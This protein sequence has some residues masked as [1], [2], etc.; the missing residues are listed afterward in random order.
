MCQVLDGDL[1]VQI[2]WFKDQQELLDSSA[3]PARALSLLSQSASA[4]SLASDGAQSAAELEIEMLSI[5]DELGSSLLFRKVQPK[6]SGN[7]T[8][9]AKNH[10]GATSFSSS[11]SV[12]SEYS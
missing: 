10:L 6:H 3:S 8:C 2:K 12:K 1:P 11:L 9:L 5:N 7:Y 4:T